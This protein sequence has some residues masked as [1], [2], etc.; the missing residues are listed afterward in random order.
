MAHALAGG[1]QA[2]EPI[3]GKWEGAIEILG[4][5]LDIIVAFDRVDTA[6][7]AKIDIP[8]QNAFGLPLTAVRV[9]PP[10]VHFELPAG[11]GL[12]VFD[13]RQDGERID[14]S[15]T[16]AGVSGTFW[17]GRAGAEPAPSEATPAG[18]PLPYLEEEVR[19]ANGEVTLAGTLS[20]P[21]GGG[22]HPA[23]VM[24]TGS[25][26]QNRD[27]E[28]FGFK[29]FRIIA[30]H[31]TRHGIAVLRY[32]DRGVGGSSG[33]VGTATSDDFAR[34]AL[35]GVGLLR[36]RAD[37]DESA[38]GLIGHS[39]GAIVAAM[40]AARSSDVRFIVMLAGTAVTGE[41]ILYAQGELILR[42]NGATEQE[43]A[44]QRAMQEHIFTA[45]RT[46]AG[47]DEVERRLDAQIRASFDRLPPDQ[48]R[49]ISDVDQ[50]VAMAV[51]QQI[52][53]ARSPWFRFFIEYDPSSA[54]E[55]VQVPVLALFGERDLQVPPS[56]NETPMREALRRAGNSDV[57][58]RI[59]PGVNH[60]FLPSETGNPSEYA[61]MKKEFAPA[62]LE[63]VTAW[64]GE[65]RGG[66]P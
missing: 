41:E 40:A 58:L 9:D 64:I 8:Q 31:L 60:L 22:P 61:T 32:D 33:N 42:A 63:A 43:I 5:T 51:Q 66:S 39:E 56:V 50:Y 25:G 55:Q 4:Q 49:N 54:L 53:S 2:Q 16:Q 18:E 36:E 52:V 44:D 23:V 21:E 13:G 47:W 12:A 29:P 37:I 27:E 28:L 11:P 57:T 65:R 59:I 35:A 3:A 34:D 38:I 6:V 7:S 46:D 14:G 48:R 24:I 26:P 20:L 19:F 17:L 1:A 30:D 45:I 15:F 62:F 10:V